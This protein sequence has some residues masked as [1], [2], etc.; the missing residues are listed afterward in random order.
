MVRGPP[1]SHPAAMTLRSPRPTRRPMAE[2]SHHLAAVHP[3]P[4]LQPL[5]DPDADPAI[6]AAP[7]ISTRGLTKRFGDRIAIDSV[8]LHVPRGCAFG[9]LGPNGAGKTTLIRVLLGL[10]PASAGE[11]RLLGHPLPAERAAALARVGAIV[12]EPRF[13]PHLTGRENLVVAAAPR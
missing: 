5:R 2:S 12:E 13:H 6:R 4:T 3:A 10:V 11:M 9:F 7:A 1:R 8:D